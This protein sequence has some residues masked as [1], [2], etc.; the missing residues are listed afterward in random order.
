MPFD[1][2]YPDIDLFRACTPEEHFEQTVRLVMSLC[3]PDSHAALE[4]FLAC[5]KVEG[6]DA[7]KPLR[8]ETRK[9]WIARQTAIKNARTART[10]DLTPK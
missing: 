9:R 1:D 7:I 10:Q 6:V 2:E 5:E 4:F 8:D 3:F